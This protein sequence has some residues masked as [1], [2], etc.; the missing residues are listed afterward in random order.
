VCTDRAVSDRA[1]FIKFLECYYIILVT[2]RRQVGTICGHAV[3]SIE[4]TALITVPHASV[5]REAAH[6]KL[7]LR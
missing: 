7:E 2:K 6:S 1:G 4:E 5:Q 3:Y